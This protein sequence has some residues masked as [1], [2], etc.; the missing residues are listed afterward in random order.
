MART[1]LHK[2]GRATVKVV[3]RTD[4]TLRDG[5]HPFWLRIT[6]SRKTTYRATGLSLHPKYWNEQK[7]EIRRSYPEPFR[8]ELITALRRWEDKYASAAKVLAED[9]TA[10][11]AGDVAAK[12]IEGRTARRRVRLLAFIDEL[13][14][15][16]KASGQVGNAG[17]YKDLRNQL[18]KFIKAEYGAEDVPFDRVTVLF[19]NRWETV[20]RASG[21]TE[22]T[23]SFRFRTLRAVLNKAIAEGIATPEKYPFAR[24]V[25]ERHKFNVGKFNTSTTK[26]AISRDDV[27]KIEALDPETDRLRLA[28]AVFLFSFY[29]GGINFVDLAQLRWR[30]LTTDSEGKQRLNYVR[31]KTGGRFSLRL[32]APAAALVEQYRSF[33]HAGPDA[34]V[35]PILNTAI[36]KTP[37]QIKNRLNKVIG[38][39][40]KDLKTLGE[41]AEID[42]PLTTYVARHS[43]ATALKRAGQS[44]AVISEAMGHKTEAV[45]AVY[46]DSFA[47]ETVDSAFESL[48]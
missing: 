24:N 19:C 35:F 47:T 44:V 32:V 40:N 31:Q 20:L 2:E 27:R 18:H 34:Y 42:T 16:F 37:M 43:F 33:T 28:R 36:H 3:Y 13:T 26:R 25:A 11:D 17:N 45:T 21:L 41:Q 15:A 46:L 14:A 12:A 4:K 10:H 23:L 29:V 39:V 8:E 7:G 38:Q 9:D 30:N 48:V 5:S 6:K 22:V 1:T